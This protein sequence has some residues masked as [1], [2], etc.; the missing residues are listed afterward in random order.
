MTAKLINGAEFLH[1]PK[2]GGCWVREILEQNNLLLVNRRHLYYKHA[3][4]DRNL[5]FPLTTFQEHL[6]EAARLFLAETRFS[7][8]LQ[9][10]PK[11]S[12][13]SV[14][15]F[16]FVRHPLSW[17]ES[18]WKFMRAKEWND[19]GVQNSQQSWH[20]NAILNGLGSD[21]FNEFVR[22][23]VKKRPGYV[24]ELMFAYTKPGI[25][26][27]GKTENLKEDLIYV[28]DLLELKYDKASIEQSGKS[29]VSE[30]DPAEIRWDPDL[31][32]TVMR[33]E[34]PAL[35]HFGYLS[36]EEKSDLG[37]KMPI[38][39]NKALRSKGVPQHQF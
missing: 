29:N 22:N 37:I 25:S 39:P 17:Y 28:L 13:N 18:W 1:I 24:T 36:D 33:L 21:D 9:Y 38:M 12:D 19:W 6:S 2:T 8:L 31:Y 30:T 26:F 3:D 14:F 15:R 34:L 20:P 35:L 16:C 10:W 27:I 23:V 11:S 4:Y 7:K 32:R 5:F